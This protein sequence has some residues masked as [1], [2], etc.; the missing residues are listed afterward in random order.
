MKRILLVTLLSVP[1]WVSAQMIGAPDRKAGEGEGPF[2]QLIIRG[3]T[4]ID[5]TGAPPTGPVDIVVENNKIVQ[6][7]S[8]GVPHIAIDPA[9][10]PKLATKGKVKE[11]DA[12]GK[13]LM[14]GIIDLHV[15]T[16]GPEKAPEAEYTYKL[17]M[18]NGITTVRGVPT[19]EFEWSLSEK[20]RSA[21][22]KIVA[23]RIVNFQV[24]GSGKEWKDRKILTPA[25]A[26]EWVQ[27]AKKNGVDGLKMFS[28]R[29]EIMKALL[30]EANALGMGS[31]AHLAQSGVAQMNALDAARLGLT[32]MT[33]FYG[34]FESM[35]ENHDVQPWPLDINYGDEQHRFGQVARQWNLVKPGGEK[36]NAL[37]DEFLKL[38][39]YINPTMTIYVA[40]RDVMAARNADWHAKYT[41][42]TQ[43]DFYTPSR[44]SHGAYWFDW[45][46]EDEVAW[47]NFYRVWMQ[48]LNEYKNRGGKVTVGSDSGFIYNLFGFGTIQELELLQE[49]GFHPLEVIRAATMYG[50]EEIFKPL[51]KPIEFGVIREGLLADMVIVDENPLQNLKVLYGTGA[52][53]LNDE[54]GKPERVGGVKYTIK[55]G[56][57]YDAKQLL[58][59]VEQMVNKQKAERPDATKVSGQQN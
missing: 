49:A 21:S 18:A 3:V 55:D 44:L 12:T 11:I 24:P 22:N 7:K 10:R 56:I 38:D 32:S 43:Q 29:P 57:V 31:T 39:F 35:Y 8:V 47:K 6:I 46:T 1:L 15:H 33:H 2:D 42:P 40:G 59:D 58:K 53:R 19:G 28:F 36:W 16:G 25:D 51:K 52:V 48:F 9:R 37:L 34:L 26:K 27:Y 54:T 13:Y 17:W 5:G 4:M 20:N 30:D 45:T 50:A 41:L 14:P 23:P